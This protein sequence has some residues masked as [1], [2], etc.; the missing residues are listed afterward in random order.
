M[1]HIEYSTIPKHII[2]SDALAPITTLYKNDLQSELTTNI[3][4]THRKI[5]KTGKKV[6]EA[7]I[8]GHEDIHGNTVVDQMVKA[9]AL[10]SRSRPSNAAN[11]FKDF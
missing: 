9:A 1:N 2:N 3:K 11:T 8:P 7:L 10:H 6:F 4:E 5:K